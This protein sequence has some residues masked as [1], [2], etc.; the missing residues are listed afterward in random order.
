MILRAAILLSIVGLAAGDLFTAMADM[1]SMLV[2]ERDVTVTIQN[3][4]DS[5]ME[6]LNKLER[7]AS[8]YK[9]KVGEKSNDFILNPLNAFLLIQQLQ[10]D[11]DRVTHEMKAN[12][13]QEY[14]NNITDSRSTVKYPTNEDLDG[15]AVALLRLQDTYKLEAKDLSRGII[16]GEKLGRELNAHDCFEIGRTAYN[17]R[18][19]LHSL[20]WMKEAMRLL[21]TENPPSVEKTE[22]L[23][24]L[25]YDYYKQGE[26]Q[27]AL[28][29]TE[30]LYVLWPD[31]PRAK[32]NVQWYTDKLTSGENIEKVADRYQ[33]EERDSYEALC[34]GETIY[35][36]SQASKVYCY[37]KMDRPFLKLAPIKVEILRYEPLA[38]LFK[39]V[40]SDH[41]ISV[42][43]QLAT[44]K[45]RRATVQNA[46]TGALETAS[47]RISKSAWL[48][49]YEH[50][51]VERI[52]K[53]IDLMTNLNQDTSEDLQIAN[54][55]I[56]GH[57]EPHY[58]MSTRG[59]KDPY[60]G[61]TGNRLGTVLFYVSL[62]CISLF[63]KE[64][65]NAFKNLGTG[66]R[67][68]TVLFYMSKPEKGGATVFT[69]L[70]MAAFPTKH[71]ALFWYNL[72][73][74]G[75]GDLRTRHAACPVLTGVKWVSNKWIHE[76]GQE[77]R[78]PCGLTP[79][80]AEKFVGDLS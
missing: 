70:G 23:E 45:L 61:G 9:G 37:L 3:Y 57:Y 10:D 11:W 8:E 52:N 39:E 19:F 40:I 79:N 53:R 5:E 31:H 66:N 4:I 62:Y 56:G 30:E 41:E 25:A 28:D 13:A 17:Q 7:L 78:R 18:T 26:I 47:Y 24:Y 15:A 68:S 38:V 34:R 2:G 63:Q 16:G 29:L 77:F 49:A 36:A 50:P 42:V 69:E 12:F 14:I 1:E 35:N 20:N 60:K 76:R 43:Q 59:E 32:G 27:K 73:R 74:D 72:N 65:K 6:R 54:Y 71:D 64:E 22:I 33:S 80:A 48:K 67:I 51:V 21:E 55:G 75:Q 58:D 46:K 44:P